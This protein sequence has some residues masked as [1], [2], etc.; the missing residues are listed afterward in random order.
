[1]SHGGWVIGQIDGEHW[2]VVTYREPRVRIISARRSR[3][4]EVTLYEG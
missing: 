3:E 4:E 2:S 1:M